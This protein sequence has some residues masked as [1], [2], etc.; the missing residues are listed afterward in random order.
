MKFYNSVGPN[1]KLVRMFAAE[2]GFDLPNVTEVDIMAGENRQADYTAKNPGQQL[3]ALELDDGR[4]LAET[5]V[6]CEYIEEQKP[7][8][9]LIG[10]TPEDRAETRMWT[11][12]IEQKINAPLTDG[13]RSSE[14]LTLFKDRMRTMPEAADDLKALARDGLE[15]LDAQLEGR[16]TIVPGRF[17]LA[18]V[19]L[20]AIT[21]FGGAVGQPI[22][23]AL[24]N[25]TAWFEATA[26]RPSASA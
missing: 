14:G 5:I 9:S 3:P 16:T 1:P 18:D 11:R 19:A 10:T 26:A 23:P 22:D 12:R 15:W 20:Y 7:E 21:E 6:L 25:V 2:K 17:T 8:P 4:V 24:K 13:F